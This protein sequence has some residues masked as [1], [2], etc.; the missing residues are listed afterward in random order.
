MEKSLVVG[1]Q[2][3]HCSHPCDPFLQNDPQKVGGK[4]LRVKQ[5]VCWVFYCRGFFTLSN[6][7]CY[8][9]QSESPFTFIWINSMILPQNNHP[10]KAIA[11]NLPPGKA[12]AEKSFPSSVKLTTPP[13]PSSID[14]RS[15][16]STEV[17]RFFFSGGSWFLQFPI[18]TQP[19]LTLKAFDH[20]TKDLQY[21]LAKV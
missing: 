21:F 5:H 9:H 7:N 4:R 10:L 1:G 12:R 17:V 2:I 11:S 19:Q 3:Y 14:L 8:A 15:R 13:R 20:K 18:P 16:R 6:L